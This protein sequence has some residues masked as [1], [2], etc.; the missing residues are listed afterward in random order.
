[1]SKTRQSNYTKDCNGRGILCKN[2]NIRC[3]NHGGMSTGAR[4]EPGKIKS[5]LNLKQYAKRNSVNNGTD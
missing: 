4:T 1:M 5:K 2:G 3:K